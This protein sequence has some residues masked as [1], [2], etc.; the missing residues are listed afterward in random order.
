[1]EPCRCHSNAAHLWCRSRGKI[2]IVSGYALSDD[3]LWCQRSWGLDGESII[4]TTCERTAYFG[5]RLTLFECMWFT[6][7]NR[8][9][10]L[11]RKDFEE[12]Q[13]Y[14]QAKYLGVR[15]ATLRKIDAF[16]G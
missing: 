16:R 7:Y 1:M 15:E 5:Y 14:L 12:V 13:Y 11:E 3:G 10:F 8:P 2:A 9:W 6:T 4:E